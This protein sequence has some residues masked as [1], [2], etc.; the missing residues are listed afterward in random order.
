MR[1]L[2]ENNKPSLI[3]L[4]ANLKLLWLALWQR[5][6][7]KPAQLQMLELMKEVVQLQKAQSEVFTTLLKAWVAPIP[8]D[9]TAYA[10]SEDREILAA[11]EHAAANGDEDAQ[12]ILG[13]PKLKHDYFQTFR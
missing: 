1:R 10:S 4:I 12:L 7:S 2:P 6:T 9:I 13:D 5:L 8:T 3:S 11:L